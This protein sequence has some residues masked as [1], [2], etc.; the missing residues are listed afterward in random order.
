MTGISVIVCSYNPEK[1][2]FE[3]VLTAIKN[4]DKTGLE[5]FECIIVDNNSKIPFEEIDYIQDIIGE[6]ACCR[7][8][9]E[10]TQGLTHARMRGIREASYE[11]LLFVDDDNEI[12]SDFINQTNRITKEYPFIAAFNAGT[13]RVEYIGNVP[14]WFLER[15]KSHFQ[16]SAISSFVWGNDSKSYRH[17]PFGTGLVVKSEVGKL[18]LQK[19]ENGEYTLTDRMGGIL[20]S[21]GDGQLI[22]CSLKLGYGV[23]RTPN[24]HLNHLIASRKAT[25]KYICKIDYGISLSNELF[26]KECFPE[27]LVPISSFQEI[28]MLLN[29]F[30]TTY[31]RAL[32]K[33]NR[34]SFLIQ[35]ATLIGTING[36]RHVYGRAQSF[37]L[38]KLSEK[39]L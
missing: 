14:S 37:L 13:I 8:V 1:I 28:K 12:D 18:Y 19:V 24:L 2:I 21:G 36:N 29:L 33:G 5:H 6:I 9:I 16:E 17:W 27:Q 26:T 4:C 38:R 20:T 25:I 3:R 31:F 32:L 15:G 11:Y 39:F 35:K 30:T 23:G 22:S 10:K 7:I 34:N